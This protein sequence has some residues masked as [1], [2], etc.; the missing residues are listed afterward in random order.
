MGVVY[1]SVFSKKV[2]SGFNFNPNPQPCLIPV[3]SGA[4]MNSTRGKPVIGL[5]LSRFWIGFIAIYSNN[6]VDRKIVRE[7]EREIEIY[8][9]IYNQGQPRDRVSI[10]SR[11]S[12]CFIAIYILQ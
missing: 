7:R 5:I 11:V 4:G 12:I 10:L 2:G 1:V 3:S 9:Y 8:K 6:Y